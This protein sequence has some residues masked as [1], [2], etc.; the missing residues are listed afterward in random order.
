MERAIFIA[1]FLYK[2][3][4]DKEQ[5][6]T[7]FK[8]HYY[9][10]VIKLAQTVNIEEWDK[11]KLALSYFHTEH[12][13]EAFQ[14]FQLIS[15]ESENAVDWFNL[16]STAIYTNREEFALEALDKALNFNTE[17]RTDGDGIPPAY[18]LFISAQN[19]YNVGKYNTAFT[20]INRLSPYYTQAQ[21]T[22]NETLDNNGIP[23]LNVYH[24]LLSK[25]LPKQ[26]IEKNKEQ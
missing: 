15:S 26:T 7:L 5:L 12:Y 11:N 17:T 13:E 16:A 14:L 3:S 9:E 4:M 10:E 24:H 2:K 20:L 6:N 21:S 23:H 19:F 25:I 8:E 18:M 22:D 1:L